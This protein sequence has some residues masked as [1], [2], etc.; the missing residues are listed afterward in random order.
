MR[1]VYRKVGRTLRFEN[2]RLISVHESGEAVEE[3]EVFSC[4]PFPSPG[5]PDSSLTLGMTVRDLRAAVPHPLSIERLVVSVGE[6]EHEFGK[7]QW[8]ETSRRVHVA[9]TYRR[10]RALIDRGDFGL[11]EVT[12]VAA[13]LLRVS[14]ERSLHALR[15]APAVSAAVLQN[16]IGIAP[17]NVVLLQT[18]GG[19]D[20]KGQPI[21]ETSRNWWRP[22]YRVRPQL[23]PLNIRATCTVTEMDQSLPLAI[24]LLE[25]PQA[26][27]IRVLCVD[28]DS[29]YP[30]TFRITRIES[31]GE[32]LTWYPYGAGSF[33][34]E[35]TVF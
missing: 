19:F 14:D 5:R 26:L 30:A 27:T 8:S 22:S 1:E 12:D 33:G 25:P 20:G 17:P 24:A 2:D 31:I 7:R 4:R 6:A 11:Q 9:V 10:L 3:G 16:L 18:A 29:V 13:A 15:L 28:G 35:M 34:A 32:K 21:E 23:R